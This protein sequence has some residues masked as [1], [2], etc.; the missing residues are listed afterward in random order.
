MSSMY[1][2]TTRSVLNRSRHAI[3][4]DAKDVH[5]SDDPLHLR[6]PLD[7]GDQMASILGYRVPA[8]RCL[9]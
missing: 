3:K 5:N 7:V 1:G 6:C 9:R 2:R 8:W 4:T